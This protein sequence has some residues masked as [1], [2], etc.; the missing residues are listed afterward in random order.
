[1]KKSLSIL[2]SL[3]MTISILTA[4]PFSA[5]AITYQEGGIMAS[6]ELAVYGVNEG[7]ENAQI[8][9]YNDGNPISEKFRGISYDAASNTVTLDNVPYTSNAIMLHFHGMGDLTV[10]LLGTSG[11]CF[12]AAFETNVNITG[13]GSL[14]LNPPFTYT[15][16]WG[17][18][19]TN[20]RLFDQ[21]YSAEDGTLHISKDATVYFNTR[22][23][24]E[25][26]CA[27]F[28]FNKAQNPDDVFTYEGW[29]S[30]K[31]EIKT[32]IDE[33]YTVDYPKT[34]SGN[35]IKHVFNSA[36]K[37][38]KLAGYEGNDNYWIK[39]S[40]SY[41][42]SN[43]C[44]YTRL[45]EKDGGWFEAL[46]G[47][48]YTYNYGSWEIYNFST[49]ERTNPDGNVTFTAYEQ[50]DLPEAL[51]GENAV[52]YVRPSTD[53]NC[54]V[55][56]KDGKEYALFESLSDQYYNEELAP[57][58]L[59][60]NGRNYSFVMF[61]IGT[62]GNQKY[63]DFA[64]DLN[65]YAESFDESQSYYDFTAGAKTV[66][67]NKGYTPVVTTYEYP[68]VYHYEVTNNTLKFT[69]GVV[70]KTDINKCTV[71]GLKSKTYTGKAI[72]QKITVKYGANT[73]KE[74]TDYTVKYS[75]NTK[76]GT[77]T[78][79]LTGKGTYTGTKKVT[80]KITQADNPMTVK[81]KTKTVKY[82]DVKKKNVTV[83]KSDAMTVSK[84]QGT[85]TF[86]KSSGNSKITINKTSGKITV[87]KGLKKGTYKVKIKVSAAGNTNYKKGLKTV[88]VTIKVK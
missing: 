48:A 16:K 15:T 74:G 30:A 10:K 8:Y 38:Y 42:S 57:T 23:E 3:M 71:N 7:P 1:M 22:G 21:P 20:E 85:V 39:S 77:A 82:S 27:R 66:A 52:A 76:V 17:E 60:K 31:P 86:A 19:Y 12:I 6:D 9:N 29:A 63:I 25:S 50:E 87:K 56:S 35:H 18:K 46:E 28:T 81:A 40:V 45:V 68:A 55:Y 2:L 83:S 70:T 41:S 53:T 75:S 36:G 37:I 69:P 44:M 54:D 79:T 64:E 33:A 26:S 14:V 59:A 43:N 34:V 51:Q 73:L 49:Y 58:N 65:Y 24:E 5:S 4:L 62:L 80:F 13:S 88:T 78:I 72:T 67:K 11:L 84:A 61:E 32:D 47:E